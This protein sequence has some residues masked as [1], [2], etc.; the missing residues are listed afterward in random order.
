MAMQRRKIVRPDSKGR[1]SLGKL[2]ENI[3]GFEIKV[4]QSGKI[5]LFP[6]VEIPADEAWLYSN[7]DAIAGVVQGM[8]EA[9]AGK[10]KSRGSFAKYAK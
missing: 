5:I 8:E 1:I 10:V 9:R 7:K 4:E 6:Q 2:A 3:S